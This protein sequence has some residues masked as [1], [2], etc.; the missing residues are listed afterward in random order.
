MADAA[1][2]RLK[3]LA[4]QRKLARMIAAQA[5]AKAAVTPEFQAQYESLL[6]GVGTR[7][8]QMIRLQAPDDLNLQGYAVLPGLSDSDMQHLRERYEPHGLSVEPNTVNAVGKSN[9]RPELIAHE[10]RHMQAPDMSEGQNRLA[11]AA[12]AETEPQW[13]AA[14]RMYADQREGLPSEN[15]SS[16]FRKLR[17]GAAEGEYGRQYNLGARP[18]E[19]ASWPSNDEYQ[20]A[21]E[22][23]KATQWNRQHEN[24]DNYID[25]NKSLKARNAAIR[26]E[27]EK[28]RKKKK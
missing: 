20:Y 13:E 15:L 11:D 1:D 6:G 10:F 27:I 14:A 12:V 19:P 7:D 25:W 4:K 22:R 5:A 3:D 18:E 28:E 2:K 17:H 24:Y 8:P 16:L 21:Q 23:K 26:A 9:M